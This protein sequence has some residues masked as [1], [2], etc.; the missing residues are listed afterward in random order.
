MHGCVRACR[1]ERVGGSRKQRLRDTDETRERGRE[2]DSQSHS[3]SP[4]P[5]QY[6]A[7]ALSRCGL[8]AGPERR[9]SPRIRLWDARATHIHCSKTLLSC[10]HIVPSLRAGYVARRRSLGTCGV[11]QPAA[12]A[13]GLEPSSL[14]DRDACSNAPLHVHQSAL[15]CP[16][17]PT[18]ST[19]GLPAATAPLLPP[20]LPRR[21]C[22]RC[23]LAAAAAA[24][25]AYPSAAAR[26]RGR[27]SLWSWTLRRRGGCPPLR[28]ARIHPAWAR[29]WPPRACGCARSARPPRAREWGGP[30]PQARAAAS[31]GPAA[32][33][34]RA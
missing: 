2:T 1:D 5:R 8:C 24:A 25:S 14:V 23:C 15:P 26:R 32:P 30:N 29:G 12:S 34:A 7:A 20:L 16:A 28:A 18:Y 3:D 6:A 4:L 11:L 31:R 27:G 9:Q 19:R 13:P 33:S 10:V 21:C 17:P 22:R